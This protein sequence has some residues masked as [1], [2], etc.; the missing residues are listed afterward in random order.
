MVVVGAAVVVVVAAAVV[1]ASAGAVV[2]VAGSAAPPSAVEAPGAAAWRRRSWAGTA[3]SSTPLRLT[4]RWKA[5][6]AAM[7]ARRARWVLVR[8]GMVL[9][10]ALLLVAR[11]LLRTLRLTFPG[12]AQKSR[13]FSLSPHY[14]SSFRQVPSFRL[15]GEIDV[16]PRPRATPPS[17]SRTRGSSEAPLASCST[18]LSH[19]SHCSVSTA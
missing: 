14:W 1:V 9:A 2:V 12:S 3:R 5:G 18:A 11:S 17:R 19:S 6:W 15:L 7:V 10:A 16:G 4:T 13:S 8:G